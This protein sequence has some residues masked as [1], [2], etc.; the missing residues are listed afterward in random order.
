[1]FYSRYG[2]TGMD[3]SALGFGGMR[4]EKENDID[5][6]AEMLLHAY[7][8][9]INY[10][11]TAPSYCSSKSEVIFGAA[12][13]E[14]KKGDRPFYIS[15]KSNKPKGSDLRR[16]LENS[17]KIMGLESID[18]YHCWYVLTLEDWDGR[19]KG[20]AVAEILKAQEEGLIKV[21]VFSTHLPGN[22][23]RTVIEEGYFRGVTL[24]YSAINSPYREDGIKAAAENNM[25]VVV[26]NPLGGGTIVENEETFG[27]LKVKSGQSILEGALHFLMLDNRINVRLVGFR[28]KNDIDTAVDAI[29]SFQPYTE[30]EVALISSHVESDF[31]SLCTTCMYCNVCPVDIPVWKFVETA[32]GLYLNPTEKLGDRLKWHWGTHIDVLDRCTEC[33][34]C[35][36]ACTQH[37]PILQRFEEL[38]EHLKTEV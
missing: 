4:F 5:L 10:F 22:E 8:R 21:P 1:M 33:R 12:I 38:K 25:G 15:T 13:R 6:S 26:M 20:G 18:F 23:I 37:L 32:N 24:G 30:E 17:L 35:E 7:R 14:M 16:D 31:N 2:D 3:V 36:D 34:M 27:F 29:E 19:K 28:N 9:G 11:D